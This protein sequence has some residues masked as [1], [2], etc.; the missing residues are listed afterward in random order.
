MLELAVSISI[1]A[2]MLA[3]LLPGLMFAREASRR[4]LCSDRLRQIGLAMQN[5]HDLLC[6]LPQA[7]TPSKDNE[8]FVASWATQVLPELEQTA[9]HERLSQ[10]GVLPQTISYQRASDWSLEIF[11]CPSDITEPAFE[12]TCEDDLLDGIQTRLH[13]ADSPTV[14]LPTANYIGVY[15]TVEA[16]DFEET[17]I[18]RRALFG[19][20]SI[21]HERGVRLAELRR[22]TSQTLLVGE[23]TMAFV[24]S[25]WLGVHLDGAD[26]G[27]RLTGSAITHPNCQECDECE[28]S[29][30]H[31]GGALFVWADGHVSLIGDSIDTE[32][33]RQSSRRDL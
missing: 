29:S 16:D 12:L 11:L 19:D 28:F 32:T 23:R 31:V 17:P 14:F 20:G 4:M 30:R 6:K 33:Y 22:G 21:V 2:M 15:G 13:S 27:C 1:V 26:A 3:I 18:P 7:W 5:H 8:R 10:F 25:T 9:A 24:P